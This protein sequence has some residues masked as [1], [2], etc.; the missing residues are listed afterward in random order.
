MPKLAEL[1]PEQEALLPVVRDEWLT[2]GFSTAPADRR[3]AEEGMRAAYREAKL[4]PPPIVVWLDSPLRGAFGA[5]WL[6]EILTTID[7]VRGQVRG[8][9]GDQV[10]GQVWD[11][12][13]GQVNRAFWGQHETWLSFFDYFRRAAPGIVGPE[14]LTGLTVV[15]RSAGWC[16]LF[17]GGVIFIERPTELHRDAQGRLHNEHAM[18]IR[19]PDDW[20]FWAI[21]GVR[22]PREIVE[23]PETLTPSSI[24]AI[25]NAEVRRVAIERFG[26]D[27]FI[28][29]AGLTLIDEQPDPANHPYTIALYETPERLL[30]FRARVLLC[31][32]ASPERSGERRRFGLTVPSHIDNAIAAAA[33]TFDVTA[34]QYREME[35][36]S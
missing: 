21:H 22:V 17:R 19:Y 27:R 11:Q 15:A 10:R 33:W 12:V 35:R 32:N 36:A 20:G 13:R 14:R 1:S 31:T 5:W 7:Q 4:A 26:W 2:H 34:D 16:W 30:G 8:Q 6:S 28:P 24:M 29:E 23:S 3:A 9:V 25:S 18:A